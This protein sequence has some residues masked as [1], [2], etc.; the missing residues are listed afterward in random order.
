MGSSSSSLDDEWS[1]SFVGEFTHGSATLHC[2]VEWPNAQRAHEER[3][4]LL[5]EMN[6]M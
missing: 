4:V 1:S 6:I 3:V 2:D 5:C